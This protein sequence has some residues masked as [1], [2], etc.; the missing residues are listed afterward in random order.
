MEWNSETQGFDERGYAWKTWPRVWYATGLPKGSL[1]CVRRAQSPRTL[2]LG[3]DL[4]V[5]SSPL[6][7][8]LCLHCNPMY[9]DVTD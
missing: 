7:V 6:F 9:I 1:W 2:E 5:I 8:F 3:G 4:E